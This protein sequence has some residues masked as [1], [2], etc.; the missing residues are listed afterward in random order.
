MLSRFTIRF[1]VIAALFLMLLTTAAL[2]AF[3]FDRLARINV[4]SEEVATNWLPATQAM[5]NLSEDFERFRL[6]QGLAL[7]KTDEREAFL[8]RAAVAKTEIDQ[9]LRDYT[10]TILPGEEEKL[11]KAMTDALDQYMAFS[12]SYEQALGSDDDITAKQIYATDMRSTV[13]LVRATVTA[14][15]EF[16]GKMGTAAAI[17]SMKTGELAKT[18]ILIALG[19]SVL[20]CVVIGWLMI[21]SISTPIRRMAEAMRQ[22]ATGDTT[23]TVP[24]LGETNEIGEMA[25][26]VDIF[27]A[28]MIYNTTLEQEAIET[29][30]RTAIQRSAAM[31]DLADQFETT[32]GGIVDIVSS[33]AT[34]M[35]AT[36]SQ[37]TSSAHETSAQATSVSAAAEEAG[38][39]VTSVAG[40]AEELGASVREISRQVEHSSIKA[41]EAVRE[42]DSTAAIVQELSQAAD[43]INGIVDMITGIAS[44]TNLLALNATIESA[45]AGEAG[46]GFAVVASE[47]KALAGQTSRATAEI[48][49][50]IGS[51]QSTTRRAVEAISNITGTIRDINDSSSTIAAAV[52]QQGSATNEIVQAVNQASMGTQEVTINITGVA[53]LAEETGAGAAQVLSASGELA[54]QAANLR[55]QINRFLSHIRAA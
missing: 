1:R 43:R 7:I 36:A 34:E 18:L 4:K 38:T 45:R 49:Q 31:R 12:V 33:A 10:P 39:N 23:S 16:Q 53:R 22:L 13:D 14:D 17:D 24:S 35:Q 11:A 46:R 40:S 48:S 21:T 51:I 29:R 25:A 42:A 19:F 8:K 26:A 54:H 3:A 9:D 44:Q 41:R 20:V 27:K 32:V 28:G 2:G 52:E 6:Y 30:E 50:H 47:V 5:G 55:T 37:L 15:R